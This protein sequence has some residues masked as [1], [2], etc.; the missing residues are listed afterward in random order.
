MKKHRNRTG[1]FQAM[2]M[3]ANDGP[4]LHE[5]VYQQAHGCCFYC[6]KR[7]HRHH[8]TLDH[9]IPIAAGGEHTLENIVM[10]CRPCNTAKGRQSL[11]AYREAC[12]G[13]PFPGEISF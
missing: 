11:D 8:I 1:R 13:T 4:S 6:G 12:G 5:V 10:S 3:L 7:I 9:C 2:K